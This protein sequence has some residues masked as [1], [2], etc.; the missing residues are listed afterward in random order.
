MKTPLWI[1]F[2]FGV[3][4]GYSSY[5]LWDIFK[6][7][8]RTLTSQFQLLSVVFICLKLCNILKMTWFQAWFPI[9]L[10]F[11]IS[12]V[13][14]L[15]D[16]VVQTMKTQYYEKERKIAAE[17]FKERLRIRHEEL[18]DEFGIDEEEEN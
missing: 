8:I 14:D 4:R 11:I 6:H 15:I 10:Y 18:E 2:F 5:S 17:T 3:K 1:K 7:S 16:Y 9:L 12:L 13:L